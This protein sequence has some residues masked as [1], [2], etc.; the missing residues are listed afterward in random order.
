MAEEV[1]EVALY[2]GGPWGFRLKGGKDFGRSLAIQ[3]VS[4]LA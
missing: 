1:Y 3:S 2:G 4:L